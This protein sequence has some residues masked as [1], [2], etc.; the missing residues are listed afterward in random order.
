MLTYTYLAYNDI[1]CYSK[2]VS[3]LNL[4]KYIFYIINLNKSFVIISSKLD[5]FF[6]FINFKLF[7]TIFTKWF[8][9][10]SALFNYK[11]MH[12]RK[13]YTNSFLII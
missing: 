7:N 10:F 6:N 3:I 1:T 2:I 12:V 4:K 11:Y 9:V 13:M 5:Y 8:Y